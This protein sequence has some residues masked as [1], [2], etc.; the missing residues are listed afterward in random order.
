MQEMFAD[1]SLLFFPCRVQETLPLPLFFLLHVPTIGQLFEHV[2]I[3]CWISLH[4]GGLQKNNLIQVLG[5]SQ[6]KRSDCT[7]LSTPPEVYHVTAA[8]LVTSGSLLCRK[9]MHLFTEIRRSK[10]AV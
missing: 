1:L 7:N 6:T 9:H 3:T 5:G 4:F 8:I 2:A 10:L